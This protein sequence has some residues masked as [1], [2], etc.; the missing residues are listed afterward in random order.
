MPARVHPPLAEVLAYRHP[1]TVARFL[2]AWDLEPAAAEL[3]FE[4]VLRWLWASTHPGAPRLAI[5]APLHLL[6][7]MW[8]TFVLFTRDY[9]GFGER[10]FGR[11]LHHQPTTQAARAADEAAMLADP[12]A[13]RAARAAA[14]RAQY[15]FIAAHL[16]D[17]VLIRWYVDYPARFDG[18]FLATRRRPVQ[19]PR[20]P[21]PTTR[22]LADQL[23]A[24]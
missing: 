17:E 2:D 14:D 9:A 7:E 11:F 22:Q 24:S 12:D 10:H 23:R 20:L 15:A 16:G 21:T 6:D 5:T 19:P 3:L 4:D 13:F 18:E 8:H 1:D